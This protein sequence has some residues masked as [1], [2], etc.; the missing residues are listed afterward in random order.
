MV[1]HCRIRA[2]WRLALVAGLALT[3]PFGCAREQKFEPYAEA[4]STPMM[5]LGNQAITLEV[6]AN[7]ETRERGLQHRKTMPDDHGMI[8]VFPEAKLLR[9][10]MKD[11]FIPLSIAFIDADGVITNIEDMAPHQESPG[12]L[13]EGKVKYALELNKGAICRAGNQGW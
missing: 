10:W 1:E 7:P 8:F 12:A 2:S 9:F 3:L 6:S 11:T 4:I 13:S 5:T